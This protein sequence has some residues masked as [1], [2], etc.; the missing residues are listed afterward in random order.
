MSILTGFHGISLACDFPRAPESGHG[1]REAVIPAHRACLAAFA[2]NTKET[3]LCSD[4]FRVL[5][6]TTAFWWALPAQPGA[7][8]LKAQLLANDQ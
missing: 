5:N 1:E 4:M 3:G 2:V 6:Q 7:G 8:L